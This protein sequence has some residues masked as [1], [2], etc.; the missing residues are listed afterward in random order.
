MTVAHTPSDTAVP[1][2][3]DLGGVAGTIPYPWPWYGSLVPE[4]T[5]L[6]VCGVQRV[7]AA[8]SPTA[9][10]VGE[11]IAALSRAVRRFGGTVV[12]VRHRAPDAGSPA[13]AH[14]E[15]PLLPR[16]GDPDWAPVLSPS[17]TDV[18]VDATGHDG[19]CGSGLDG[20]LR[21]RG[22][23]TLVVVGFA[24]EVAVSSTVR[25]ANDR[26]YEC[27]TVSDAA[28]PLDAETGHHHLHSITMSGGIF[29][30]VG[31]TDA[32]L[33]ALQLDALQLE[34]RDATTGRTT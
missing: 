33:D 23:D 19:F 13:P 7:H 6:V 24:A 2:S 8:A 28:A 18:V 29:G 3:G 16:V 12:H 27:L 26:G 4:R 34:P 30:A 25:A 20:E 1:A 10:P 31:T 5:G 22:V 15:R 32:L 11:R 17:P 9:R 14:R 21:A